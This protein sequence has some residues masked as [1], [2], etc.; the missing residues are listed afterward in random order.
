MTN[1]VKPLDVRGDGS[2]AIPG[3]AYRDTVTLAANV[4]QNVAVPTDAGS[5]VPA[6]YAFF[7]STAGDFFANYTGAA[8]VPSGATT[9]GTGADINPTTRTLSGVTNISL[10]SAVAITVTVTFFI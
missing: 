2:F 1:P 4:A 3:I 7:S 10:I 8:L 6:K 9:D 5:G